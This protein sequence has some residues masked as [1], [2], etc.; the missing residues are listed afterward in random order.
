[1]STAPANPLGFPPRLRLTRKAQ[2]DHV[3]DGRCSVAAFPLRLYGRPNDL[4]HPR[5]GLIVTRR[6]G[7]AVVRNR[8]KRL[9]RESFRLLQHDLPQGYDLVV[10]VSAH[11][12]RPLEEYQRLLADAA[13]RIQGKW[14]RRSTT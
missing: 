12:L 6:V 1:M 2:F 5:L 3:F 11:D 7:S 10:L 14:T 4:A 8:V 13:Q 9:L